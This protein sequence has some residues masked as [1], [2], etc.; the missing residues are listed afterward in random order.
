MK[1]KSM[2]KCELADAAGV[3]RQTFYNWTLEDQDV[4]KVMGVKRNA[5]MLPPCA[6]QYLCERYQI[7]LE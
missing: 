4:L 6:V 7:F 2:Y 5:K 1:Y 3:S